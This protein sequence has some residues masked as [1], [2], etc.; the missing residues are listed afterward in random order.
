[1]NIIHR[2]F[3]G[4]NSAKAFKHLITEIELVLEMLKNACIHIKEDRDRSGGKSNLT[5]MF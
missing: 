2:A 3:T 5:R 1:M 4:I